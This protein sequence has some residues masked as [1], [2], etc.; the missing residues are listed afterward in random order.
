MSWSPSAPRAWNR[1]CSWVTD[2]ERERGERRRVVG[3]RHGQ[4]VPG[5][6]DDVDGFVGV[7]R[8]LRVGP[9]GEVRGRR[10]ATR[11]GPRAGP[12]GGP[13]G[14]SRSTPGSRAPSSRGVVVEPSHEL[15]D[16]TARRVVR[17]RLLVDARHSVTLPMRPRRCSGREELAEPP[18]RD[19][20]ADERHDHEV[21]DVA[22]DR[23]V[24]DARG[25][26]RARARRPG[27]AASRAR[28]T[29]ATS[30]TGRSGR[31]CRRTGTSAAARGMTRSKSCQLRRNVHAAIPALAK[32]SDVRIATGRHRIAHGDSVSPSAHMQTR[33]LTEYSEP[34]VRH[35]D[36]SPSAMSSTVERRRHHR[37]VGVVDLQPEER[38]ERRVEHR[39]VHRRHRE[40]AR[41]DER[42]VGDR[43][44]TRPCTVPMRW[45]RPIPRLSR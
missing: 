33:K 20:D 3:H 21:H 22:E 17:G 12:S 7:P 9:A 41:R 39:A 13:R 35:H 37:V 30:G 24:E 1:S 23:P 8:D 6:K 29:R 42:G 45:L 16:A 15:V 31:T 5:V 32:A 40:Q 36:S 25:C 4:R 27:T 2:V 28:R 43:R 34:R 18:R 10:G 26:T 14:P 38:V 44:W 19:E 11:V